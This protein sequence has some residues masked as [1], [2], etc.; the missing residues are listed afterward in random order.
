MSIRLMTA[1]LI[2]LAGATAAQAE[3]PVE[4]GEYLVRGIAG[5]GNCHTPMDPDG[6]VMEQELGGRLVV[7]IEPFTAYAHNI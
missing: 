6:F 5:C 4:R 3:T 2:A 1:I 7:D